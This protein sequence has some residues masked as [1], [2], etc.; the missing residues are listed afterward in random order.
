M[1]SRNPFTI[2]LAT[3]VAFGFIA[4]TTPAFAAGKEKVLH[5]FNGR[6][7]NTPVASLI[8]DAAGNLYGTT[9][10]GGVGKCG[11]YG[12]GTVFQLTLGANGKWA[13]TVLHDFNGK[14][15]AMPSGGLIVDAAGNLYGTTYGGGVDCAGGGCGTV[16]KLTPGANGK[17]TQ[18]VL[19]EFKGK[20]GA[21][22][23]SELIFDAA[24]KLYG[25]TAQGGTAGYGTVFQL[26]PGANGNWSDKVLHNFNGEDGD[27]PDSGLIFDAAGN[28]YGTTLYSYSGGVVFQLVRD[29]KGRWT[30][31][32]LHDFTSSSNDSC[33]NGGLIFDAAGNLYGTTSACNYYGDGKVFEL[34][35][36]AKG[37]WRETTVYEFNGGDDGAFPATGVTFDAEGNLYGTTVAGGEFECIP[38]PNHCGTVFKLRPGADGVWTETVVHSFNGTDGSGPESSLVLDAEGN[39]YGTTAYGGSFYGDDNG[40][41]GTVFQITP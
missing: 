16:F 5:S 41:Y 13:E 36:Q 35:P 7:G 25:T 4:M 14:D 2:L 39:L 37:Q 6:G 22:P 32:V 19:H 3:L 34:T 17:W 21:N 29:A 30:E 10:G 28:L 1:P 12:C 20:D 11:D 26:A 9:T 24:G 33:P 38:G 8:F 15:G 18:T 27:Y 23:V 40:G 31:K